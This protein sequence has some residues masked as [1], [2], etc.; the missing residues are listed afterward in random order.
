MTVLTAADVAILRERD[1]RTRKLKELLAQVR[2][3]PPDELSTLLARRR[4]ERGFEWLARYAPNRGWWRNCFR[5][6]GMSRV[7]MKYPEENV[8]TLAFEYEPEFADDSGYVK[9]WKVLKHF[10]GVLWEVRGRRLGFASGF[11][12]GHTPFPNKYPGVII[13][14]DLLTRL[15]REKLLN[16][17]G[18]WQIQ[19]RH[20]T[21]LDRRFAALNFGPPKGRVRRLMAGVPWIGKLA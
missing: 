16:V 11:P 21:A 5:L 17:P 15:W 7:Q 2:T 18:D 3:L 19:F 8:V 20:P 12:N 1:E 9:D 13:T 6:G 14:D 10:F 4:V